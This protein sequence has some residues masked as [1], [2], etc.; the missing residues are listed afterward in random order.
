MVELVLIDIDGVMTDGTKHYGPD[1]LT[2]Y[3]KF[4]DRDFTAIKKFQASDVKVVFISGDP[5]NLGI[6]KARNIP[7][8]SARG[9]CKKDLG[10]RII[11]DLHTCAAQTA[12]IGDDIFD[13]DLLD[14]VE[15]GFCPSDAD[16][17]VKRL[18]TKKSRV[19]KSCG[20]RGCIA[21]MYEIIKDRSSQGMQQLDM[22]KF[23]DYDRKETF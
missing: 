3:K 8:Y 6:A 16:T 14:Y 13:I 2:A 15:L 23:H 17:E 21:E 9:K 20:G 10:S 12:Y 1:G 7:F 5:W 11:N 22:K 4:Y 19:L 18:C